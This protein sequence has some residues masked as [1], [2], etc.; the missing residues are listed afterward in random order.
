MHALLKLTTLAVFCLTAHVRHANAAMYSGS[1]AHH[2][3]TGPQSL[4]V[5][6]ST[7]WVGCA[8]DFAYTLAKVTLVKHAP[9]AIEL[10][11][12]AP[13]NPP[14][15][16][17]AF[18]IALD[19]KGDLWAC[20]NALG[21]VAVVDS[22]DLSIRGP[23]LVGN[24]PRAIAVNQDD[25]TVYVVN[26]GFPTGNVVRLDD[27]GNATGNF[28]VGQGPRALC[29]DA[30]ANVFVANSLDDSITKLSADG[31]VLGT[32]SVGN[33][34][35]DVACDTA[36]GVVWVSNN[37]DDSVTQLDSVS[38]DVLGTFPVGQAP[39]G[40]AVNAQGHVL[41]TN[42][43]DNTV[44]E[45]GPNGS[46][47]KTIK[48]GAGPVAVVIALDG[49]AYVANGDAASVSVLLSAGA[50]GASHRHKKPTKKPTHKL[51]GRGLL[52]AS[53]EAFSQ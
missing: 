18:G 48:V 16:K 23:F 41:V 20:Q 33:S 43:G 52:R 14:N 31:A 22:A 49:T 26:N 6:G 42:S 24:A 29:L 11:D 17:A 12:F 10:V 4:A 15:V 25:D 28:D 3:C 34:P 53:A 27:Q 5:S 38:G 8:A 13:A 51:K 21:Q 7:L 1:T 50:P 39:R 19:S 44:V 30:D 2:V 35:T 37:G 45:L 36:R 32:F 46:A 47:L 9:A 40:L